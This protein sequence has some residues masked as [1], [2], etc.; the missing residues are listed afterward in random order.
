MCIADLPIS[1][2]NCNTLAPR[3]FGAFSAN[4]FASPL[5]PIFIAALAPAFIGAFMKLPL[6][7][8]AAKGKDF[9]IDLVVLYPVVVLL[10]MTLK[11][12][13]NILEYSTISF[14]IGV[15]LLGFFFQSVRI[16]ATSAFLNTSICG[17][18]IL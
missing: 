9:S 7:K 4:C 13:T 14:S 12:L 15:K 3:V 17:R 8:S 18:S 16:L 2:A 1:P 10:S 5:P 11:A 6:K